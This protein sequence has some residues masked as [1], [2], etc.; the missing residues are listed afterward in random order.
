M[1]LLYTQKYI[2]ITGNY[3]GSCQNYKNL[4]HNG[5][6]R[7]IGCQEYFMIYL[8]ILECSFC[9]K[10][11]SAGFDNVASAF[12]YT[13]SPL[14]LGTPSLTSFFLYCDDVLHSS[15]STSRSAMYSSPALH[16]TS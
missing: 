10:M 11:L 13:L 2:H 15:L 9:T 14:S 5:I 1:I 12:V 8:E 3:I 4:I 7:A 16:I 6:D